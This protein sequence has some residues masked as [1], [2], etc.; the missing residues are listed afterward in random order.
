MSPAKRLRPP[1][2]AGRNCV[3]GLAG[4]RFRVYQVWLI[5]AEGP[6]SA[7]VFR[8]GEDGQATVVMNGVRPGLLLAITRRWCAITHRGALVCFPFRCLNGAWPTA[9]PTP[10]GPRLPT[11]PR[12]TARDPRR[13]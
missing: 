10:E 3:G 2:E 5:D 1:W 13:G 8:P 6:A 9:S 4:G 12:D 11:L 7:G